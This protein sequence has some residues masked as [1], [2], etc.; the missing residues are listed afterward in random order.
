MNY[1]FPYL[2]HIRRLTYSQ[3]CALHYLLCC[4]IFFII[5]HYSHLQ[6]IRRRL[7][8][9]LVIQSSVRSF[10]TRQH[11][12]RQLRNEFDATRTQVPSSHQRLEN[13]FFLS[14]RLKF[15]YNPNEDNERLVSTHWIARAHISITRIVALT[16]S[17]QR[18][19]SKTGIGSL[20]VPARN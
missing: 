10:L 6:D 7:R 12:K 16:R 19:A 13:L 15:F 1:Y 18:L 8:C 17:D 9:A 14:S 11:L 2:F 3:H 4:L 5:S 20:P